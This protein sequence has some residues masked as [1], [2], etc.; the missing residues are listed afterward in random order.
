MSTAPVRVEHTVLKSK[1]C[2]VTLMFSL[3]ASGHVLWYA[4]CM[5][6][7]HHSLLTIQEDSNMMH[8]HLLTPDGRLPY[9]NHPPQSQDPPP[10][11]KGSPAARRPV[12]AALLV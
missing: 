1:H 8:I 10:K 3:D 11:S 2:W 4:E 7:K 6:G 12:A 5:K 9:N